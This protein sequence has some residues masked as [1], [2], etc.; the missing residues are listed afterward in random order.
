MNTTTGTPIALPQYIGFYEGNNHT[1]ADRYQIAE[2]FQPSYTEANSNGRL[3]F[4]TSSSYTGG[5]VT[6]VMKISFT[7]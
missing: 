1:G 2:G 4:Q 6:V 7:Y 3:Q 5:P